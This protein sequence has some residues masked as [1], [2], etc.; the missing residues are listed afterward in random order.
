MAHHVGMSLVACVN[1]VMDD[2][3]VP[4]LSARSEYGPGGGAADRTRPRPTARYYSSGAQE[5]SVPELP[6]RAHPTTEEIPR[7]QPPHSRMHLLTGSEWSLAITDSG[8][9][10]SVSR[11]LDI[12]MRSGD[13]CAAPQGIFAYAGAGEGGLSLTAAPDSGIPL[14]PKRGPAGGGTPGGIRRAT[15]PPFSP[16]GAPWKQGMRVGTVHPRLPSEQR[17]VAL[18]NR[19]NRRLTCQLLFYFRALSGAPGAPLPI[20]LFSRIFSP[21]AGTRPPP[22][23]SS[24]PSAAGRTTG[25]PGGRVAG[26]WSL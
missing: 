13:R 1:A 20:R 18:K 9:G 25:M 21:S 23:C 10:I 7:D 22:L 17:Q 14:S 3:F 24:P 15:P 19:S 4:P 2:R 12:H 11:G 16:G 26:R 8:A 5:R 6:G